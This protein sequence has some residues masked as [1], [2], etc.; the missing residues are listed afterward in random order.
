MKEKEIEKKSEGVSSEI[1]KEEIKDSEKQ[2]VQQEGMSPMFVFPWSWEN[3]E[4]YEYADLKIWCRNCATDNSTDHPNMQ[5]VQTAIH[6]DPLVTD[7]K[8]IMALTCKNC[9]SQLVVHFRKAANPPVEEEA[10]EEISESDKENKK[11]EEK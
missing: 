4:K 2:N 3:E 1:K 10:K 6:I 7:N 5:N 11:E 8:S 9:G